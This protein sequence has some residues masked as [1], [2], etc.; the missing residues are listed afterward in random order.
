MNI[1]LWKMSMAWLSL[2]G[3]SLITGFI[4]KSAGFS[5]KAVERFAIVSLIC[6]VIGSACLF[7]AITIEP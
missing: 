3:G 6:G 5:Q 4:M 2:C 1:I 7:G